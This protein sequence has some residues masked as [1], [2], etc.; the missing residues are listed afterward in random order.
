[1]WPV[2]GAWWGFLTVSVCTDE[3]FIYR[4][5]IEVIMVTSGSKNR[6][7]DDIIDGVRDRV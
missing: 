7:V 4:L 6:K 2:Q 1:M 3:P 5:Q